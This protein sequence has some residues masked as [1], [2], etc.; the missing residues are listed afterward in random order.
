MVQ[1]ELV[2]AET[3]CDLVEGS[4]PRSWANLRSRGGGPP[5][6]KIGGRVRYPIEDFRQWLDGQKVT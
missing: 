4:T 3:L 2:T 1:H 6:V 5:F